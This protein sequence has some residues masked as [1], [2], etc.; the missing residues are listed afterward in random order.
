LTPAKV[1]GLQRLI[2]NQ[3]TRRLIDARSKKPPVAAPAI[4]R[5]T[6]LK[7]LEGTPHNLKQETYKEYTEKEIPDPKDTK[8]TI[9]VLIPGVT[10][11]TRRTLVKSSP[12]PGEVNEVNVY[13]ESLR[14]DDGS[15]SITFSVPDAPQYD[16]TKKVAAN[17]QEALQKASQY[18]AEVGKKIDQYATTNNLTTR[19]SKFNDNY[20][21]TRMA[22]D[23]DKNSTPTID[24][25][26]Y[27]ILIPYQGPGG[28][29]FVLDLLYQ[30]AP[31]FTGY[32]EA[33]YDSGNSTISGM[34][35]MYDKNE[36]KLTVSTD[37]NVRNPKFTNVHD[38][39]S[40]S[41]SAPNIMSLTSGGGEKNLDAYT[42][43]A[44]EGA[45]WEAVRNH[46]AKLQD[47]S[48]FF[49]Q[50]PSDPQMVRGVD[51]RTL[52]LSW[53]SVFSKKYGITDSV[54]KTKLVNGLFTYNSAPSYKSLAVKNL[55]GFDYDL[56]QS[57]SF[58]EPFQCITANAG[59]ILN[60][61]TFY[62][63]KPNARNRIWGVQL[64]D[65]Y[66]SWKTV[67]G[68]A[69]NIANATI[70]NAIKNDT[71]VNKNGAKARQEYGTNQVRRQD[72]LLS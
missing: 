40:K 56:D 46:A 22:A 34:V 21:W 18:N 67:F 6:A 35:S 30:H 71:V 54:F 48:Y 36:N 37:V 43:I 45:R 12:T 51:F 44:G 70:I 62:I 59:K 42:K 31:S 5:V 68:G 24:P 32:V 69:Y 2:G 65:L 72:C 66:W 10:K 63:S 58:K 26:F 50:D 41:R 9:T 49:T 20:K 28:E 3:A 47:N 29:N 13:S 15:V 7:A 4:Q 23:Q 57:A 61:T 16:S 27:D 64:E 38:N 55:T 39:D 60:D 25:F 19:Y 11:N 14:N 8:K 53:E 17:R 33:I 52:W 1:L